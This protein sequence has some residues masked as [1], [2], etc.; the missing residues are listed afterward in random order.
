MKPIPPS[1]KNDTSDRHS[2]CKKSFDANNVYKNKERCQKCGHSK[3]IQGFQCPAKEVSMQV[4][5]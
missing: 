3:Y 4:L 1:H 2:N 5:L